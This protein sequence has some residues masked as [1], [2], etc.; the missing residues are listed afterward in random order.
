MMTTEAM[1]RAEINDAELVAESLDGNRDAF[2]LIVERYQTLI[3]SQHVP[4]F[5]PPSASA[6]L[7]RQN[8][9]IRRQR[10]PRHGG[11]L[12]ERL[13]AD[14]HIWSGASVPRHLDLATQAAN[15]S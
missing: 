8:P 7:S 6:D 10:L 5:L 14:L 2:R 13:F 1:Q 15:R 4:L 11:F 9:P 3:S 12:G